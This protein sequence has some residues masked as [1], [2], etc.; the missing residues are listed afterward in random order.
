MHYFTVNFAKY[1]WKERFAIAN[2]EFNLDKSLNS[3]ARALPTVQELK[4]TLNA[5]KSNARDMLAQIFDA[6]TFIELGAFTKRKF[7]EVVANEKENLLEGVICG[8]GAI[9]GRLSFAFAQDASRMKGAIDEAQAKK[10]CELYDLALKNAAPV[11]AIFNCSGADIFEG[12]ASLAAYGK[13]MKAVAEASG[14]IPQIAVINGP[15]IGTFASVAAMFDYVVKVK[16]VDYYVT[17]PAL[18]KNANSEISAI[19][20]TVDDCASAALHIRAVMDYI[21]DNASSPICASD[22]TDDLNKLIADYAANDA[23]TLISCIADNGR[24]MELYAGY[25]PEMITAFACIGGVNCGIV[26][27][28]FSID[29]GRITAD[30]A[31]KAAKLISFC[32]AFN[33]P[34]VTLV[35][36]MGL[37]LKECGNRYASDL[38][39]L[40]LAYAQAEIPMITIT[41]GHAIGAAFT[42]LGSK[43]MG[44]DLAYAIETSEISALSSEAS[45]AF[46]WNDKVS[47]DVSRESLVEEWKAS[48]AS[49]VAAASVGEI[50]DIIPVSEIRA[51][52]CSALLMLAGKGEIIFGKHSVLPL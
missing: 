10:I 34:I 48:L 17:A 13:I 16:D 24:Y 3:F 27:T 15:C 8:Y 4:E 47:L 7:N 2:R 19:S 45:V 5:E 6:N 9:N 11:V 35:D 25:A 30:G 41:L 12:A 18:N 14:A 1:F 20:A 31:N 43:A 29:E 51:R 44:A 38:A 39:K 37:S 40:S 36:S 21:P 49:P 26:A 32:D 23:R 46:A 42:I 22:C 28:D 50:D 52:I 33:I